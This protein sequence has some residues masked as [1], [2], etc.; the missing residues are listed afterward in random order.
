MSI[1]ESG[2]QEAERRIGIMNH[3]GGIFTGVLYATENAFI[4]DIHKFFDK[5]K[6]NLTLKTLTKDLP[7]TD[8]EEAL[9]LLKS[10]ESEIKRIEIL[11]HN[12]SAHEPKNPIEEKIFTQEIEKLFSVVQQILNISSKSIGG[13]SMEWNSWED[14]TNQSFSHLVDDLERGSGASGK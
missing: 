3:Y 6:N 7:K 4:V 5:S 1:P 11:R 13:V 10:I 8:K 2:Q 9:Q 14:S 12:G